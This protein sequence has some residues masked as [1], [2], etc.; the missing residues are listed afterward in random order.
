MSASKVQKFR[1][2]DQLVAEL[3]RSGEGGRKR[4]QLGDHRGDDAAALGRPARTRRG[5]ASRTRRVRV[6]RGAPQLRGDGRAGGRRRAGAGVARGRQGR[7]RRDPDAQLHR[8]PRRVVRLARSSA[9]CA[10]R[11]TLGSRR[12]SW[13][14]WSRTPTSWRSS[15]ATSSSSTPTTWRCCTR[16]C[17]GSPTARTRRRCRSRP[18]PALRCAVL[19]G[20]RPAPG[21]LDRP[22]FESRWPRTPADLIDVMRGRVAVRD[23]AVI[24]YTSG[25]TAMPQG[26]PARPRDARARR[27]DTGGGLGLAGGERMWDP[28]PLFHRGRRSRWSPCSTP[29]DLRRR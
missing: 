6:P 20:S 7:S 25:T 4:A 9:P 13:P 15:P 23:V 22:G 5:A 12:A 17:P 19:L 24:F 16:R 18:R 27:G 8:L 21:F 26:L 14:T 28:L 3:D 11:S 1:L 2:R 29:A 10:C